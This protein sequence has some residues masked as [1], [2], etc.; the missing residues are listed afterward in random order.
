MTEYQIG[1]GQIERRLQLGEDGTLATL[2]LQTVAGNVWAGA[3]PSPEY[4]LHV[5]DPA[6]GETRTLSSLQTH[7]QISVERVTPGSQRLKVVMLRADVAIEIAIEYE[8]PEGHAV[9]RHGGKVTN[10]GDRP[11]VIDDVAIAVLNLDAPPD[12]LTGL[13]GFDRVK[14][15]NLPTWFALHQ[16]DGASAPELDFES[17][18][19]ASGGLAAA[20]WLHLERKDSRRGFVAGWE[21]SAPTRCTLTRAE[22]HGLQLRVVMPTACRLGPGESIEIPRAF[23]CLSEGDTD[24]VC[25]RTHRFVEGC[26]AWPVPD[27]AFPYLIFNSWGYGRAITDALA[28]QALDLCTRLGVEVFVTDFGWEGPDWEPLPETFPQGLR[29]LS[30]LARAQG[31][32]FGLHY[33]F[34]NVS[35]QSRM[36]REHPDWA[37]GQ[38]LWAYGL[39]K[40]PVYR[41]SL[42]LPEARKWVIEQSIDV[43]DHNGVDWFLTDTWLWGITDPEKHP[44]TADPHWRAAL[45]FEATMDAIHA[46]RPGVLIEHCDGGLALKN[47][48]M[49]QQHVTSVSCDNADAIE[50]RLSVYDLSHFLPP[51]YLDKYQQEWRSHYANRSCMLGGPW[52]LMMPIHEL[53]PGSRDWNELIEDIAVYKR[54]RARIRDGKILHLLR[55]DDP[56]NTA[57]DGW[58]AIGSYHPGD[59]AAIVFVFRTRGANRSR[60]VPMKDLRSEGTY[61]VTF[62]DTG[63]TYTASGAEIV[64]QGFTLE[65]DAYADDP[66][67]H[68]SE[69]IIIEPEPSPND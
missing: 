65:L 51:R 17:R 62:T 39:D 41:V 67:S 14:Q 25:F 63:R 33:S 3:V 54:H 15:G 8:C 60:V 5:T 49:F 7:A 28:R 46:R 47:Y 45:G 23:F 1:N 57:W 58:D 22:G 64:G 34:G 59:D 2:G 26:L 30:D 48:K 27:A 52:I 10:V 35:S 12:Q 19:G 11:L 20:T 68:C 29:P 43:L 24:E 32:K 37:Y 9:A 31:I 66:H 18:T 61:R 6:T 36:Y 4:L 53:E 50:T 21:T 55:P 44:I 40:Y 38:G 16:Y 13:Y 69:I 56:N 42:G